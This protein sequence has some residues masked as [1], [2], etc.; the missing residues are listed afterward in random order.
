MKTEKSTGIPSANLS[1]DRELFCKISE[2]QYVA[3]EVLFNK[4]YDALCRFGLSYEQNIAIVEEKISDV[5]ILLWNKRKDL[6]KIDKPKSYIYVIAKNSL[7]KQLKTHQ[8]HRSLDGDHSPYIPFSP[9]KEEEMIDQEQKEITT[10]LIN[11]I[12]GSIPKKSRRIFE[13]SRIDGFKYKEISE[14]VN[15]SPRTVEN[16]IAL[17]MRY[18][19]KGLEELHKQNRK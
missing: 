4:Y 18:I 10:H 16:H 12:L 3:L 14:I 6:K 15:L 1:Q 13:L 5:F 7:K 17:A 8:F 9:S 19:G 2:G 11:S